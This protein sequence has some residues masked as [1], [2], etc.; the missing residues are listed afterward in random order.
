VKAWKI[1]MHRLL[2]STYLILL[3]ANCMADVEVRF[4]QGRAWNLSKTQLLYTESHWTTSENNVL[5][6]RTVVYRCADGTAFARKEI[7][8]ARSAL[9]PAFSFIDTR[10]NYQEGLRWQNDQPELWIIRNGQKQQK[11][12]SNSDTLV[13]DAGFD[14]FI[15]KHWP[16][17]TASR[18][19][20]LQ[21]A[22]PSRLTS[23]GFNLQ[24]INSLAFN[25]EPAQS[26]KLG[27]DSW[28]GLIAP[29]IEITYS[30]NTKRLLRF[31]GLSNILND[32][33]EKPVN[34][35]IE[36]PLLDKIVSAKEKQQAQTIL[37]KSCQ[38]N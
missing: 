8:Y 23:Y 16:A 26:F 37:L 3:S 24:R 4:E 28:L 18:R 35:L 15:K 36:F 6:N 5:K 38:L 14:V 12:L 7:N 34:A 30:Q 25:K 13:A 1:D 31:K 33:G 2:L 29:N 27:L 32:Q 10:F 11:L 20:T 22:V 17:L 19:Q 21:F 9:A